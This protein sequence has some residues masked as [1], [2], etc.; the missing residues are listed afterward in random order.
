MITDKSNSM[1]YYG[2]RSCKGQATDDSYM[3]SSKHLKRAIEEYGEDNFYKDI[4]EVFSTREQANKMEEDF[5]MSVDARNNPDFYNRTNGDKDWCTFGTTITEEH[6]QTL[7]VATKARWENGEM[8]G[9][10]DST[11]KRWAEGKMENTRLAAAKFCGTGNVR[12]KGDDRTDAQLANDKVFKPRT[13]EQNK[14]QRKI[15][16][17]NN[18]FK[19][20]HHSIEMKKHLS[21]IALKREKEECV[22]CGKVVGK[23]MLKRWHG[24]NCKLNKGV[25]H[26]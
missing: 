5:L 19:G 15:M 21:E 13:E 22:H 7:I 4:V 14:N 2:V 26:G 17:E 3:S 20:K 25:N 1:F 18:P 16:L 24:D 11:K 12:L 23:A 6:K 10:I 8:Q 9:S